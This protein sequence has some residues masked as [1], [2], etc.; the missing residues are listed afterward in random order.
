MIDK[1]AKLLASEDLI[2][3]HRK[4][5][6]ASFDVENRILTLPIWVDTSEELTNMLVGHEVGHALYTPLSGLEQLF[7]TK[8]DKY[9]KENLKNIVN[10][11]EDARIER[12]IK[13]KYPGLRRDFTLGYQ[14]LLDKDFFGLKDKVVNNLKFID[15]INLYFKVGTLIDLDF[16]DKEQKILDEI[17]NAITFND[18]I[19]ISYRLYDHLEEEQIKK[20]EKI[21]TAHGDVFN[22][23]DVEFDDEVEDAIEDEFTSDTQEELERNFSQKII[24]PNSKEIVYHD[25]YDMDYKPFTYTHKEVA[26]FFKNDFETVICPRLKG[27]SVTPDDAIKYNNVLWNNF[28]QQNGK[29]VSYLVK[30][31][32]TKK[33]ADQ[34]VRSR[35]SKTGVINSNKLHAYKLIDDVFRKTTVMPDSKNH[36]LVLFLDMSGSMD[37]NFKGVIEQLL[38]LTLFCRRIN[39]PHRVYGF[40]N[41]TSVK[42]IAIDCGIEPRNPVTNF[43][44]LGKDQDYEGGFSTHLNQVGISTD[45]RLL[46]LFSEKMRNDEFVQMAKGFLNFSSI[47]RWNSMYDMSSFYRHTWIWLESTPLNDTL[48]LARKLI[49]DFK[50]ETNAQIVS[51]VILTDGDSDPIRTYRLT[52]ENGKEYIKAFAVRWSYKH[53]ACIRDMKTKREIRLFEDNDRAVTAAFVECLKRST[54]TKIICYRIENSRSNIKYEFSKYLCGSGNSIS[55]NELDDMMKKLK[56]QNYIE[57]TNYMNFSEY[58]I[59]PGGKDMEI[60]DTLLGDTAFKTKNSLATA[61]IK[62]NTKRS[63][64]RV[65]LSKFVSK[66]AA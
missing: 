65:M 62:A 11:V 21:F 61:F 33:A 38:C 3:E 12:K 28:L 42:R 40:T 6:T 18:V 44:D 19:D 26:Q 32:E 45:T 59:I 13:I 35:E 14:E 39:I 41:M 24:D 25:V 58:Y 31:F 15:K 23:E 5:P 48:I 47:R 63:T 43:P 4:V 36:G 37:N 17:E 34:Y 55:H 27:S 57:L 54:N 7:D 16:T 60:T 64:S 8:D 49:S 51:T 66:I 2:V 29:V 10:V 50:K 22:G 53:I 46:E 52:Q 1:L 30:E 9:S 20:E 56:T